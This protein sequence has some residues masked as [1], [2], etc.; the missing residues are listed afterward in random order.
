MKKRILIIGACGQIGTELTARL[1]Q[2]YP[3]HKVIASDIR[4]GDEALM[5]SGPFEIL[6]ATDYS[7]IED[8]VI[9]HEITEV[10]LMA[11]MLSATGEKFPMKAWHLNMNSLFNVLNLAKDGKIDKVFW[12]SSIAVFG[13]STPKRQTPQQTIMEPST[14]YGISKQTGERWCEYYFQKYGVDV[15]SVR[16][17][18]L[19]S[20]KT[21]PGG[22]TTDYAVDIYHK[23]L[24]HTK[25]ICFLKAET[26]LPM[27]FMDDAI[28]ATIKIM[29]V[30]ASKIKTRSSYNLAA[31]SF[32]P[33]EIAQRI[34][35][36]LP[37]FKISYQPDFRQAIADSWPESIDDTEAQK[38]W[39]W[40]AKVSLDEM[41]QI[42][43]KNLKEKY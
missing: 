23:A 21:L 41:T 34:Q 35:H 4:E 33:E 13:P 9:R 28:D 1:R 6:D 11:A 32:N 15:R 40:K 29:D 16:Y 22:G 43:L 20:Y 38:D 10:Y 2:L 37:D 36:Y 8:V 25:Y 12:P 30:P 42:M 19:I 5:Q 26:T 31:M 27:M 18:G 17:P 24:K 39:G 3:S 14:V 7:A